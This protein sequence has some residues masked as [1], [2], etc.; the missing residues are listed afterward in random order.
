MKF[1]AEL[2]SFKL[3][4]SSGTL[5]ISLDVPESSVPAVA[6]IISNYLKKPLTVDID[7]DNTLVA[8][9]FNKIQ[10]SQI[11]HIHALL[12]EIAAKYEQDVEVVKTSC[13][14]K[15]LGSTETSFKDL[16]N[17]QAEDFIAKLKELNK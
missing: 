4:N 11:R 13:K 1:N 2:I 6:G 5:R 15:W 9:G 12:A 10:D 7:V 17:L 3:M 14:E 8:A 16:S